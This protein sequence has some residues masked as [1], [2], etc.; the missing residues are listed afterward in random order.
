[1]SPHRKHA[2]K[3]T[4][5]ELT[6]LFGPADVM[7]PTAFTAA[8]D[9]NAK[10]YAGLVDLNKECADFVNRRLMA[11]FE[12]PQKLA[13]CKTPLDM[14]TIYSEF[15]RVAFDDYQQGFAK[16]TEIGHSLAAETAEALQN[17]HRGSK[18]HRPTA[19]LSTIAS[20]QL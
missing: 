14:F 11:D 6:S 1:M 3:Q 20:D 15:Y 2:G 12:L 17:Q 9:I 8:A 13:A 5:S 19:S 10:L 16:L 18:R 7:S 4:P